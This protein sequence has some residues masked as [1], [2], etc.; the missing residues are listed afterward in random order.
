VPGG[1]G[2]AETSTLKKV[3]YTTWKKLDVGIELSF[4]ENLTHFMIALLSTI[5]NI[6]FFASKKV[7]HGE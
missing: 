3:G 4:C 5:A 6:D 7:L 2:E 1:S